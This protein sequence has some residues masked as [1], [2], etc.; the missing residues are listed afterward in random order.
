ME[1][2]TLS[3][4]KLID[5]LV[6][7]GPGRDVLI[8]PLSLP[9]R[10]TRVV[11]EPSTGQHRSWQGTSSSILAYFSSCDQKDSEL[12]ADVVYFCQP[13]GCGVEVTQP[14]THVFMLTDTAT[15]IRT[16][17]VCMTIP[18]LFDPSHSSLEVS[19]DKCSLTKPDS[20]CIQEWGI[21]SV[22]ILSRHPFFNFFAKCLKTLAHFMEHFSSN[23]LS[24]N[25]LIRAQSGSTHSRYRFD[26]EA[27]KRHAGK[28]KVNGEHKILTEVQDWINRLLLLPAPEIGG[29]GLEV[30]LEVDPAIL[31]C[32]PSKNRLPFFDLPLHRIFQKLG[33]HLVIEIFKLVLSE[34]K[35]QFT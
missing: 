27:E 33:V 4:N 25:A 8:E 5:H 7:V 18:H 26:L 13:E 15:N 11:Q 29:C 3:T 34:Q 10:R 2:P 16:N 19:G 6:L 21:L 12:P 14:K 32:Y 35:V 22:C 24:W 1:T 30:E 9:S 31:L 20:I 28:E 17:G 23:E